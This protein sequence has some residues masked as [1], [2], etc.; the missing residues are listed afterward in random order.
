[1]Q[2]LTTLAN[3]TDAS[4]YPN[5]PETFSSDGYLARDGE[6]WLE[7][8]AANDSG[9]ELIELVAADLAAI[10]AFTNTETPN[11]TDLMS[12][13]S[14]QPVDSVKPGQIIWYSS[15]LGRPV[16]AEVITDAAGNLDVLVIT[17]Y[18]EPYIYKA[19]TTSAAVL[20]AASAADAFGPGTI[21]EYFDDLVSLNVTRY[22]VAPSGGFLATSYTGTGGNAGGA[23]ANPAG[24][25]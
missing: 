5:T 15:P 17:D 20:N 25:F 3:D 1:M 6:W 2:T 11:K 10:D 13:V 23:S 21:V 24:T 16:H 19:S 18:T 7:G 22:V 14:A 12:W 8:V 4:L 9:H